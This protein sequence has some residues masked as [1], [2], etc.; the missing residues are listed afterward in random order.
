MGRAYLEAIGNCG[1]VVRESCLLVF[2]ISPASCPLGSQ[3]V[4][5]VIYPDAML[6]CVRQIYMTRDFMT[7]ETVSPHNPLFLYVVFPGMWGTTMQKV[8][9]VNGEPN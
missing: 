4:S 7:H 5:S 1:Q 3:Q 8:I 6:L 2:P 9:K